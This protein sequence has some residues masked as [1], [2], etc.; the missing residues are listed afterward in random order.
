M[1]G[2]NEVKAE[3]NTVQEDTCA[4]FLNGSGTK[5][6]LLQAPLCGQADLQKPN[7]ALGTRW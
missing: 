7:P 4:E 1:L 3:F 6:F 5:R 2:E